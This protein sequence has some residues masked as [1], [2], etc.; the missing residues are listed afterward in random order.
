MTQQANL[1]LIEVAD[2]LSYLYFLSY[3][4]TSLLVLNTHQR[5]NKANKQ[6]Q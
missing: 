4:L 3:F 1:N 5:K 6:I 2:L